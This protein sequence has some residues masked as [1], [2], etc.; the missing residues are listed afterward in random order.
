ML[1]ERYPTFIVLSHAPEITYLKLS[2]KLIIEKAMGKV[3]KKKNRKKWDFEQFDLVI[4]VRND[5]IANN[6][7]MGLEDVSKL[8]ERD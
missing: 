7:W 6:P 3:K 4:V 8:A 1:R 2:S 5:A